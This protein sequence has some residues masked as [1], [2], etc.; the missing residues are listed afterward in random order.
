MHAVMTHQALAH[1]L[2]LLEQR[3]LLQP[4][5]LL[6]RRFAFSVVLRR[7]LLVLSPELHWDP[8]QSLHHRPVSGPA[9]QSR[10]LQRLLMMVQ[11]SSRA[12][13]TSS[14]WNAAVASWLGA[15]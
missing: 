2:R 7:V 1:L 14:R 11:Q 9:R 8:Y 13:P 6:P 4:E 10:Q 5:R 15:C 12:S 3:R